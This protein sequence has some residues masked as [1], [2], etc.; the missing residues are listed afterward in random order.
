M[1]IYSFGQQKAENEPVLNCGKCGVLRNCIKMNRKN[2]CERN[3][4]TLRCCYC[5]FFTSDLWKK[6]FAIK[7]C[8]CCKIKM[9]ELQV[10]YV[11]DDHAV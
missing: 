5:S 10:F 4:D 9:R 2:I 7:A 6:S 1:E 8:L 11:T 3:N